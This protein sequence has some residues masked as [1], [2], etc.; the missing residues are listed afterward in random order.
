[1]PVGNRIVEPGYLF[2]TN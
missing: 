2:E 1:L